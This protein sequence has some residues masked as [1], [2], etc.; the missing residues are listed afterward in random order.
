MFYEWDEAKREANIQKHGVDSVLA[1][2]IFDGPTVEATDTRRDY[3][4]PRIGTTAWPE[5]SC[6]S[7]SI[8]GAATAGG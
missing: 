6:F 2:K 1:A 5:T 4:E 8:R 3:G 7:L